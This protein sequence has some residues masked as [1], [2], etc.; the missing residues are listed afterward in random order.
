[1]ASITTEP[2]G[3]RVIQFVA[4]DGKRRSLRLGRC[5]QRY[6]ESVLIRVEDL[7]AASITG[8][9][10]QRDTA[11]WLAKL[12]GVL[13]DRL[14]RV[15][16]I[17]PR[18]QVQFGEWLDRYIG[19]R[20]GELKPK[21]LRALKE[22]RAKLLSRIPADASL[23]GVTAE[24]AADWRQ[25]LKAS[26]LSE[27]SLKTHAGNAKTFMAAAVRRGLIDKNPFDILKSG[28]TPSKYTHYGTPEVIAKVIEACP[29]RQWALLF[30]LARYAGLRVPSET[31]ALTVAD[32]DWDRRRLR[33]RSPKTER[34]EGHEQRFVPV[35]PR[36]MP[37]LQGRFD[38]MKPGDAAIVT[39]RGQGNIARHVEAILAKAGVEPWKRLWQTLRSSCEK[40]WAMTFPQYAVSKWIGHS[41]TVSGRHYANDV[42]DEL[43]DKA[44]TAGA[45]PVQN[46]VQQVHE[47]S[48]ND[49]KA[50]DAGNTGN[51]A[52]SMPCGDLLQ[53][54]LTFNP[55][56]D[57]GRL[58]SNQRPLDPQS[59]ALTRLRHAPEQ[60]QC[61][62]NGRVVST[63]IA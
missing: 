20:E 45:N 22:T 6:A 63:G 30:G 35:D 11:A 14:S 52:I 33:V 2:N 7:L 24:Q 50:E 32:V 59:S 21:S 46:P 56:V 8:S 48:G 62:G 15:G 10:P 4:A 51:D 58:D 37:L 61:T 36:L 12:D 1:M 23:Q 39:I 38:E 19:E 27:A 13:L 40:Q 54:S 18:E 9:P 57:S 34:F 5:F 60:R 53:S 44:S 43:F 16:L 31:H 42:P 28:P 41:I 49:Q 25:T 29:N 17:A 55:S 3:R 26:G 47:T